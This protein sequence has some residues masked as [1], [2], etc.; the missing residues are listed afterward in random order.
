MLETS[1]VTTGFRP[2][3][4]MRVP[5]AAA[6]TSERIANSTKDSEATY[7][8]TVRERARNSSVPSR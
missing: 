8:I 6:N 3:N 2:P 1:A 5:S 4:S 7:Q